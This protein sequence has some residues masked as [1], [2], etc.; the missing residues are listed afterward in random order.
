MRP[1]TKTKATGGEPAA[2]QGRSQLRDSSQ[3]RAGE[4]PK[5]F[6]VELLIFQRRKTWGRYSAVDAAQRDARLLREH[7]FDA[8]VKAQP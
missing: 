7:G 3:D 6:V 1:P 4:Q 2:L 5:P 8:V